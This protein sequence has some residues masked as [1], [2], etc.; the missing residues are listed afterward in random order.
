AA[1]LLRLF[2]LT[3][4]ALLALIHYITT[5]THTSL[6]HEHTR[7]L[8][9]IFPLNCDTNMLKACYLGFSH[10]STSLST[11]NTCNLEIYTILRHYHAQ[12]LQL[13]YSPKHLTF[14][15]SS[16]ALL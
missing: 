7:L 11:L 1:N 9:W 3:T 2:H 4:L 6:R 10:Y 15:R 14:Y 13:G 12:R 16:S 5:R 8:T